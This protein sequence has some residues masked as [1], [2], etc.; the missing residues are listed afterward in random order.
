VLGVGLGLLALGGCGALETEFEEIGLGDLVKTGIADPNHHYRI[1]KPNFVAARRNTAIIR[2]GPLFLIAVGPGLKGALDTYS[3]PGVELGVRLMKQPRTHIVIE[4][5]FTGAEDV[6][7]FEGVERFRFDFP[8]LTTDDSEV[9]FEEFPVMGPLGVVEEEP[10]LAYLNELKVEKEP[11]PQAVTSALEEVLRRREAKRHFFLGDGEY[12]F[13]VANDDISTLLL[14]DWMAV[15]PRK[16]KG[17]IAV[18]GILDPAIR[19]DTKILGAVDIRWIDLG[20]GLFFK[21][22]PNLTE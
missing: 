8:Y 9:A 7:L 3:G 12:R 4:R 19:R 11:A 6:D 22:R 15:E 14:L 18:E 5:V 16:F 1:K 2:E 20:S 10:R 21:S 13:L 17:G